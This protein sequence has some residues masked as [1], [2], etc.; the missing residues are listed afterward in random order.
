MFRESILLILGLA[1]LSLGIGCQSEESTQP[2]S[3]SA[4]PAPE[5][6]PP[7]ADRSAGTRDL[8]SGPNAA[9]STGDPMPE[10][11]VLEPVIDTE[12]AAIEPA[13][14]LGLP[15][16]ETPTPLDADSSDA[17]SAFV[18]LVEGYRTGQA[19]QWS[20][21]E[22][23]IHSQGLRGLPIL[24]DGLDSGDRQTRE[25]ASMMLA[26]VLPN[27]IFAND[28]SQRPDVKALSDR[29]RPF[30]SADSVEVRVNIAVALSMIEDEGPALVP[31]FQELL[32]SELA[33]VRMMSVVALGGLG[34]HAAPAI[35]MIEEMSTSDPDPRTK[36]AAIEAL[37]Q[38]KPQQSP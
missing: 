20:E 17:A 31:V 6:T 12:E 28:P 37:T 2:I 5:E 13:A 35:P 38:L 3:A 24:L 15:I 22:A 4:S 23:A 33:H 32:A 34:T 30:L 19:E 10:L 11:A 26:Q 25:L 36:A 14:G 8:A 27:L 16:L 21:A 18:R 1:A 9:K 7:P 29:L